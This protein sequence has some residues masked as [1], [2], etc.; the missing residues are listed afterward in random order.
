MEALKDIQVPSIDRPFGIELWPIFDK[1]YEAVMGYPA[2]QFEFVE[3]KTPMSTLQETA[4]MLIVY[5]LTIFGGREFMKNR[6]AYKL[7]TLFMIHNFVL[8]AVSGIL[9]ALFVEQLLPTLW[10]RGVFYSICDHGGGWTQPLIVLY[11]VSVLMIWPG[12]KA[13]QTSSTT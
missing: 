1:A 3:G 12:D 6:P 4:V 2:S 13:N 7:T 11:Y 5:Y 9:L 8:T 10:Y